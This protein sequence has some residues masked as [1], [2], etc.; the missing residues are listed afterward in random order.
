MKLPALFSSLAASRRA[1]LALLFVFA[2]CH[3]GSYYRHGLNFRDE[4]G[5]VALVA[6]RMLA[7]ERLFV[8]VSPGGYNVLW[9]WPVVALFKF[10]GVS[11]V[12]LRVF[13]FA[14][15]TTTAL[16]VFWVVER[17]GRRPWL[18]FLVASLAVLVPG[19]TFKNY[20][21]LLAVANT[22]ALLGCTLS[23]PASRER[24]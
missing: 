4:G 18:A 9:F 2:V 23:P 15:A 22:A 14:L 10:T 7:G 21:P 24:W 1:W 6:Q 11:Y 8:D 20:M 12:A 16:L 13:C 3:Y 17:A 19:M 5:T